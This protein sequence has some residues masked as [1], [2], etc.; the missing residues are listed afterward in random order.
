MTPIQEKYLLVI[1]QISFQNKIVKN[2]QIASYLNVKPS[3]VTEMVDRLSDNGMVNCVSYKGIVLTD[4]GK[5]ELEILKKRW[6]IMTTFL[7][8]QL[9]CSET[10]IENIMEELIQIKN[11]VFLKKLDL[12]IKSTN[13]AY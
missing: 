10:E 1:E 12:Y 3:S 4:K 11:P 5:Q 9:D 6:Q 2:S 7:K 8:D 13:V